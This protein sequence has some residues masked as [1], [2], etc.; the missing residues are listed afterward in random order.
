MNGQNV[1]GTEYRV[2]ITDDT[3]NISSDTAL[4]TVNSIKSITPVVVNS[5]LCNG[6][7]IT[8]K[9]TTSGDVKGYLWSWNNG[10]GW[11]S[12]TD[13]GAYSGTNS[14]QLTISNATSA[15]SGSYRVSVTFST[16]N[17][18]ESD[19]T[20]IE[21]SFTRERNLTIRELFLPPVVSGNQQICFGTIAS[22][23]TAT[24]A[25]GGS[26][27]NYSY[28][29][30]S[31]INGSIWTNISAANTLSYSPALPITTIYYRISASDTGTPSCGI[32]YSKPVQ[33]TVNPVPTTTPIYHR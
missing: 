14:S 19:P 31:S 27:P 4:L 29:W 6:E 10:S 18:P 2:L 3:G 32:V 28:Q 16:L 22:T 25:S 24:P 20:C 7:S 21:T 11:I 17:Q 1:N 30:Q 26:G 12:L 23:L 33:I 9:V 13:Q 8:Y 15:Q 5:I